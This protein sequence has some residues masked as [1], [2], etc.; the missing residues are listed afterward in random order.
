MFKRLLK[1][2]LLMF[3]NGLSGESFAANCV[4]TE[5]R[6]LR[7]ALESGG[8]TPEMILIP[9]GNFQMGA[10]NAYD[11]EKPVHKVNIDAFYIGRYEITFEE[12][13]HFCEQTQREKPSD[14]GWGRGKRPVINVSWHDAVAY[15]QWLSAQTKQE[16]RLPTEAEWEYSARAGSNFR[17]SWGEKLDSNKANCLNNASADKYV[18]TAPVGS[19]PANAFGLHDMTGNVE[20]WSCSKKTDTYNGSETECTST[21]V[22]TVVLRGGSWNSN[23]DYCRVSNRVRNLKGNWLNHYGFRVVRTLV[24]ARAIK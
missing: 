19:F 15:T 5:T 8:C 12:Y 17:Y 22:G 6:G 9:A 18:N 7:E 14:S 23:A 2:L 13:D 4:S 16:Y 20:E 11:D 21:K 1:I 3:S 10:N 24:G